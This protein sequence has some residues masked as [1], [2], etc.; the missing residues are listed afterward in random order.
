[1]GEELLTFQLLF[2]NF[3]DERRIGFAFGKSHHLPLEKIQRGDF[4]SL[5]V[6]KN[7]RLGLCS[8]A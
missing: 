2:Q 1:V 4:A 7:S 8:I 3:A 5:F 6:G